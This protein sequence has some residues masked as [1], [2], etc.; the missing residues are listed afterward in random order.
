MAAGFISIDSGGSVLMLTPVAETL[1]GWK[2]DAAMNKP[3]ATVYQILDERTR[4]RCTL[5]VQRIVEVGVA[6]GLDG[7]TLMV[8]RDGSERLVESNA[9]P[10][11]D[12]SGGRVGTVVVFRD[13]TEKRRLEEERQKADKLE[14]LGVVAGGI[15]HDFNN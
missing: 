10:I 14:S 8:S 4:K 13:V 15:A 9:A 5:A 11:R 7:P 1:T 12:R 2:Q 3:L 6:E